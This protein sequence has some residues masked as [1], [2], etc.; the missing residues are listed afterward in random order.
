MTHGSVRR[1]LYAEAVVGAAHW[2]AAALLSWRALGMISL[3]G[4]VGFYL[5]RLGL[6]LPMAV[7]FLIVAVGLAGLALAA[8]VPGGGTWLIVAA[9]ATGVGIGIATPAANLAGFRSAPDLAAS[10]AGLRGM[11]RHVG[12]VLAVSISTCA[13]GRSADPGSALVTTF[14]VMSA[15]MAVVGMAAAFLPSSVGLGRQ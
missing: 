4:A 5:S 7:G 6:R 13:M 1:A 11:F 3:S 10:V 9:A 14:V 15:V 2:E 12:A 8:A